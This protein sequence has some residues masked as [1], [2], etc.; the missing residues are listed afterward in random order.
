MSYHKVSIQSAL[1]KLDAVAYGLKCDIRSI[2]RNHDLEHGN[3]LFVLR[4][5]VGPGCKDGLRIWGKHRLLQ[6]CL[7]ASGKI[8]G[9]AAV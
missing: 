2:H 6:Q 7:R 1:Q 9:Y 5:S 8:A 3:L 4:T